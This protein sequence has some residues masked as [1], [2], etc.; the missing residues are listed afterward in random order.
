M[1]ESLM[2]PGRAAAFCNIFLMLSPV[3]PHLILFLQKVHKYRLGW[4]P[5]FQVEPAQQ[6]PL[7]LEPKCAGSEC[8]YEA[9]NVCWVRTWELQIIS[10]IDLVD[11]TSDEEELHL[12]SCECVCMRKSKDP[13]YVET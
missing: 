8:G 1:W 12:R 7:G 13:V 9:G 3:L 5:A 2:T 11:T 4:N 6:K 10:G